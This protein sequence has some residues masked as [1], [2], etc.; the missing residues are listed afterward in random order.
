MSEVSDLH[1]LRL[2][3]RSRVTTDW[4]CPRK[5]YFQYEYDNRGIVTGNT[6][7]ELFIGNTL[8]EGLSAIATMHLAGAVDIDLIA[9]TARETLIESL[10]K[11]G[12]GVQ[13]EFDFAN[14]QAALVEGLLRGFNKHVWP[15]LIAQYPVIKL[16]EQEM[17][18]KHDGL[19]FM[20]KPDLVVA[21]TEGNNW[22]VEYKST[23]SKKEGWVNSWNTAVQLHSTIKAIEATLEEKVTGVIVQGLYKGFESYGK[24]SSPFCY[25]YR[26][27]GNPPFSQTETLYAYKAGFKRYPTWEL[28]GGV[29]QWVDDMPE[30]VLGDQFPVAPPIFVKDDLIQSFF[31]QRNWR[32][33]EIQLAMEMLPTMDD[34]SKQG[35][36]DVTFPQRFD[37]CYPYFG[38]PCQY[39]KLCHGRVGN[40]LKEGFVYRESHHQ[41]EREQDGIS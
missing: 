31:S 20:S 29:K 17:L 32:E 26:R 39:L 41:L 18:F 10:M 33:H 1:E 38:K 15:R 37:Q 14:E 40:P 22:Y 7:L 16:V 28:P 21:D 4:N 23:S 13:E 27:N 12:A 8:H 3:D 6:F 36:L 2:Y 25:A 34:E 30:D 9:A 24:Q 11:G 19:G 5:R 35:I